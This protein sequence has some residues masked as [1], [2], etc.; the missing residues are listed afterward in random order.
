VERFFFPQHTDRPLYVFAKK[1]M[2]R[3]NDESVSICGVYHGYD[4]PNANAPLGA[5]PHVFIRALPPL[6]Y[7][8]EL[9]VGSALP[10]SLKL[11][12]ENLGSV[13]KNIGYGAADDGAYLRTIQRIEMCMKRSQSHLA[14]ALRVEAT[15]VN[16]Q[17]ARSPLSDLDSKPL[18]LVFD[19]DIPYDSVP[20]VFNMD[21]RTRDRLRRV[22]AESKAMLAMLGTG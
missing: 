21:E 17:T 18:E 13:E 9:S 3:F 12:G 16:P 4:N 19:I 1:H 14:V 2:V 10:L 20:E 6:A 8:R 7:L 5:P 15:A 11:S 22:V